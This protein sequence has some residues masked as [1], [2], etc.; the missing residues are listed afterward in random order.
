MGHIFSNAVCVLSWLGDDNGNAKHA[1]NLIHRIANHWP[2]TY[3]SNGWNNLPLLPASDPIFDDRRS[4]KAICSLI[5]KNPYFK[6]AWIQQEIGLARDAIIY[7]GGYKISWNTLTAVSSFLIRHSPIL[8]ERFGLQSSAR[9]YNAG[10][11]YNEQRLE[12]NGE[13]TFWHLLAIAR[14]LE[15]TDERD[16]IYCF[17][18]HPSARERDSQQPFILPDYSKSVDQ[19]YTEVATKGLVSQNNPLVLS[20]VFHASDISKRRMPSWVHDLVRQDGF[21]PLLNWHS[22]YTAGT[23]DDCKMVVSATGSKLL[24]HGAIFGYTAVL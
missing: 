9:L 19:V 21:P 18:T 10:H 17:L 24:I 4:W 16:M 12:V 20:L 2:Y 6:R 7:W 23:A 15:V 8:Y 14:R 13:T 5:D 22:D 3:E 11:L 1:F